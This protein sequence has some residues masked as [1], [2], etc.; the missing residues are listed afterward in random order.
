MCA[1]SLGETI[2]VTQTNIFFQNVFKI[3]LKYIYIFTFFSSKFFVFRF[4]FV[5]KFFLSSNFFCKK[6]FFKFFG[7]VLLSGLF[8]EYCYRCARPAGAG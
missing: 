7:F 6:F 1:S 3:F 2:E 5:F 8:C 4:F